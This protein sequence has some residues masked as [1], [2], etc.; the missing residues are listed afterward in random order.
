MNRFLDKAEVDGMFQE[1]ADSLTARMDRMKDHD[2]VGTQ[3]KVCEK[4]FWAKAL[5]TDPYRAKNE[6]R[7]EL[8]LATTRSISGESKR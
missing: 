4:R 1:L 3:C 2:C 6:M 8:E 7:A 5:T